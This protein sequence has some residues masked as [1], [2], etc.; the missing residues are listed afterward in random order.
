MQEE[1]TVFVVCMA[2]G[3]SMKVAAV[4]IDAG[5]GDGDDDV[6]DDDDDDADDDADDDDEGDDDDDDGANDDD[7]GVSVVGDHAK[8]ELDA[9]AAHADL[10][11]DG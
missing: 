6:A 7:C 10:L 4:A 1:A 3:R 2:H 9:A 8:V 11:G 5:D